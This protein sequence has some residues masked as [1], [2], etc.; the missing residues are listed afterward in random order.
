MNFY[1][2]FYEIVDDYV[3]RRAQFRD[4]H[5]TV[6]NEAVQCGELLLGG[7]MT[8][9][10][11]ALLVFRAMDRSVVEAFARNDPYVVNGLVTRW[12]VRPW[13]VVVGNESADASGKRGFR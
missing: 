2:L 8:E 1:A 7:A 4:Q 12:E 6:A 3:E 11:A 9:P 13:N 10:D 5:L